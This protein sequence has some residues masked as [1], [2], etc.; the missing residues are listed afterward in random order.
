M[1]NVNARH[2]RDCVTVGCD[3]DLLMLSDEALEFNGQTSLQA[4]RLTAGNANFGD[5][6]LPGVFVNASRDDISIGLFV[7]FTATGARQFAAQLT[8]SADLADR[9]ASENIAARFAALRNPEGER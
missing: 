9:A 8:K 3:P 2:D 5:S 6:E 1:R 4:K 7:M